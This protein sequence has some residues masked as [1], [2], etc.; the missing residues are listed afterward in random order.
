VK[1]ITTFDGAVHGNGPQSSRLAH[2]GFG[3]IKN[4]TELSVTLMKFVFLKLWTGILSEAKGLILKI[5]CIYPHFVLL[6]KFSKVKLL[7]WV[8]MFHAPYD[9]IL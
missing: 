5:R 3:S 8:E 7:N 1:R 9:L 2:S 4:A 6:L